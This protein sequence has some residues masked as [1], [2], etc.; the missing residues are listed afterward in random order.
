MKNKKLLILFSAIFFVIEAILGYYIQIT[1]YPEVNHLQFFSIVLACAFCFLFAEKSKAYAFTQL[2]LLFTVGADYFLAYHFIPIQLQG[3][4]CFSVVQT[5]Y[6][7]RLYSDD[8][9]EKRK[10]VHLISRISISA[11]AMI[12]TLLVLGKAADAVAVIS[13]FYYANLVLNLVF[14]FIQFK[15]AY[16]LAIG[17]IFFILCDTAIGL[18]CLFPYLPI[19]DDSFIYKIQYAEFNIAWAFYIPSQI[20]LAMSLLPKRLRRT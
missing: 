1:V 7:L 2:A 8:D 10:R 9:N 13:V 16:L 14:A 11:V 19:P 3:M 5:M 4:L 15:K 17:F 18:I 12:A 6:F 20:L